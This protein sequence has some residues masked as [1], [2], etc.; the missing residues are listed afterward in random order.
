MKKPFA[1]SPDSYDFSNFK[2]KKEWTAKDL[3][4]DFENAAAFKKFVGE[5]FKTDQFGLRF[6][7]KFKVDTPG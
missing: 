7:G 4:F 5:D 2:P 1:S 6:Y 3:A